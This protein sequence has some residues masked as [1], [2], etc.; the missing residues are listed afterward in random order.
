[1][2]YEVESSFPFVKIRLKWIHRHV[3]MLMLIWIKK[4]TPNENEYKIM[5]LN[6]DGT[7]ET[8]ILH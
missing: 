2:S 6:L 4:I 5:W 1:M 8:K 7:I 3:E